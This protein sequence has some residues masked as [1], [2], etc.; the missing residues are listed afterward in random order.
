MVWDLG[1][2]MRKKEEFESSRLMD[3][4]F[5]HRARAFR[6]LAVELGLDG[7]ALASATVLQDD[8]ALLDRIAIETG[9]NPEELGQSFARCSAQARSELI[10]ERGDPTPY[11]LG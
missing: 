11:R 8:A 7:S 10:A 1:R 3:F 4:E 9:R 6:L 5:R 2:A